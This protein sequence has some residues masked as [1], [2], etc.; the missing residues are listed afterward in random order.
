MAACT[1][2]VS[3]PGLPGSKMPCN[4]R[5][6]YRVVFKTSKGYFVVKVHN[7]WAPNSASRFHELA[8]SGYFNGCKFYRVV[9]GFMAQSGVNGNPSVTALWRE[10]YIKDDPPL[11]KNV[12]G[13][14]CMARSGAPNSATM[15]FFINLK[16][17]TY[18]ES[19]G[20]APF[21]CIAEGMDVVDKLYASYGECA[22]AGNGPN[23][24]RVIAEGN[25][26]LVAE[27]PLLD[28]IITATL[29]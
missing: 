21:G 29:K 4:E 1:P 19:Q 20:Y 23:Q 22:P 25:D 9:K 16:D 27:F 14:V 10:R 13:T 8:A 28:R 26:Y 7:S 5:G 18:L 6:D 15:Q 2:K 3:K 24:Q 12:R 17:N 11:V